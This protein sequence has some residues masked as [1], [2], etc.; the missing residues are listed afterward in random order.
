[1][2]CG[3]L[4]DAHFGATGVG[5]QSI[6]S[7]VPRNLGEKVDGRS[8]GQGD[9]DQIGVFESR[10]EFTG[11]RPVNRGAGLRFVDDLGS[12]PAG[13]AQIRRVFVESQ[14]KGA[15]DEARTKDGDAGN[16]VAWR[17]SQATRRPMAG[18]MMRSSAIN[19]VNVEGSSDCAPSESARSGSLW[20][21]M[22]RPSAPA[23]TAARA[24]GGTLSRRPVACEGSPMMGR[25]ESFLMTGIA[26][27]SNVLRV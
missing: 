9:E 23:A 19:C 12:I 2:R 6:G 27:R 24:M 1:M 17:H 5:D 13:N 18:A 21:S 3:G 7:G 14:A 4:R 10:R 22:I 25:C 26:A 20:T 11:E 16:E 8:N 15:A